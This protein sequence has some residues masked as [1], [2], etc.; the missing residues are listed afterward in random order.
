MK[1]HWF[2]HRSHPLRRCLV[3]AFGVL[4][5]G[6]T[7]TSFMAWGC[8]NVSSHYGSDEIDMS[9][10]SRSRHHYLM[11]LLG[12]SRSPWVRAGGYGFASH[13]F[14]NLTQVCLPACS[15]LGLAV[16]LTCVVA[17][18]DP[19]NSSQRWVPKEWQFPKECLAP[20][21]V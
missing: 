18:R 5:M 15:S 2:H 1:Y 20:L 10:T 9:W 16:G 6:S 7:I 4:A 13:L 3:V 17:A 8:E 14:A 12:H 21:E 19:P 11:V